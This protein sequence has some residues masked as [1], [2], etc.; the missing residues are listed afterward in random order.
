MNGKESATYECKFCGRT[1]SD[2]GQWLSHNCDDA[3]ET[4]PTSEQRWAAQWLNAS[5][6]WLALD[7]TFTEWSAQRQAVR[8]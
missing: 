1:F 3:T 7:A 6:V 8:A 5:D 2:A 4:K